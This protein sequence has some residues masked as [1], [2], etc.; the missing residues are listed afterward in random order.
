MKISP[1]V[2]TTNSLSY[3]W[4]PVVKVSATVFGHPAAYVMDNGVIHKIECSKCFDEEGSYA[5]IRP[6]HKAVTWRTAGHTA[7]TS[8]DIPFTPEI[9]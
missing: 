2:D 8:D 4:N 9:K 7:E 3:I 5:C 6:A 1:V